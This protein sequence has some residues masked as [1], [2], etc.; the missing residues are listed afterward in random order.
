MDKALCLISHELPQPDGTI[1]KFVAGAV[2]PIDGLDPEHIKTYFEH[3]ELAPPKRTL[4][5]DNAKLEE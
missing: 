4:R 5:R 2:Y 1:K 3:P